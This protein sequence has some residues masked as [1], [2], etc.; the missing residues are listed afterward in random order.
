MADG[1]SNN[2]PNRS[3]SLNMTSE[4]MS[5]LLLAA[6][7]LIG[8]GIHGFFLMHRG[9]LWRDEIATINIGHEP[10][11]PTMLSR[12][13]F[14]TIPI[15]VPLLMYAAGKTW[16]AIL[17]MDG[18]LVVGFSAIGIA[19]LILWFASRNT[20]HNRFDPFLLIVLQ[21]A[22]FA[23]LCWVDSVR[24]Y[25]LGALALNLFFFSCMR[26]W[27]ADSLSNRSLFVLSLLAAIH[28]HYQTWLLLPLLTLAAMALIA[29]TRP[30]PECRSLI[31]Y[32]SLSS[33]AC[34]L[35]A[36]PYLPLLSHNA[37]V[38]KIMRAPDLRMAHVARLCASTF[39]GSLGF[40]VL[41]G[42]ILVSLSIRHLVNTSPK[43]DKHT[44]SND[45]TDLQSRSRLVLA[46]GGVVL[47]IGVLL[48]LGQITFARY[49]PLPWHFAMLSVFASFPLSI[50]WPIV[51]PTLAARNAVNAALLLAV[52]V[53]GMVSLP[54]LA[55]QLS[56]VYG[57]A[58]YLREHCRPN[59]TILVTPW[60]LGITF[61]KTIG[62]EL[63]WS[64]VPPV[65][66]LL[67]HR[68]DEVAA[69]MAKPGFTGLS[70]TLQA[71]ITTSLESGHAVWVVGHLSA[72]DAGP[73][74]FSL[75]PAPNSEFGWRNGPYYEV[76]SRNTF[77]FLA[78]NANRAMVIDNAMN[79]A[80]NFTPYE[81]VGLYKFWKQLP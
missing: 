66:D 52:A 49:A 36:L 50:A 58:D 22:S 2:M 16:P 65:Q 28:S 78:R 23:T 74:F 32:C 53:Q 13:R 25:G 38:F 64:T 1:N 79:K 80:E 44:T 40:L 76:W 14:N 33:L 18:F 4:R 63:H 54:S 42:G 15:G 71:T 20:A 19:P 56:N 17:S 31:V 5:G 9:G 39:S 46:G 68:C 75:P 48:Y 10:D 73:G 57:V 34:G 43:S 67:T 3:T 81:Y 8:V 27:S 59:D 12:L 61:E 62:N 35:T 41:F 7:L 6:A 11:L 51:L 30:W 24:S 26:L 21:V 37:D 45:Q 77:T 29:G 55:K 47:A 72:I 69:W 70:E 60:E